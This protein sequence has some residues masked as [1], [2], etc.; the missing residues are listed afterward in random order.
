MTLH[1]TDMSL[2]CI[3]QYLRRK[4]N[5]LIHLHPILVLRWMLAIFFNI[6]PI[7]LLFTKPSLLWFMY[8]APKQERLQLF[9]VVLIYWY[10][11]F[12]NMFKDF[13]SICFMKFHILSVSLLLFKIILFLLSIIQFRSFEYIIVV[14]VAPTHDVKPLPV[15][16]GCCNTL[17]TRLCMRDC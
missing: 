11:L 7:I 13:Q 9:V 17:N 16:S 6:L 3:S 4:N 1:S 5:L 12:S 8:A 15:N 10:P 14:R 2:I